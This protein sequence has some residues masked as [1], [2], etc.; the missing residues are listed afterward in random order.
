[1]LT[2][3]REVLIE[4]LKCRFENHYQ[5][6]NG[7]GV[8]DD[9]TNKTNCWGR[10]P[11]DCSFN[12]SSCPFEEIKDKIL[13]PVGF[14]V[15]STTEK[16]IK[17]NNVFR[18][19]NIVKWKNW[20]ENYSNTSSY[21]QLCKRGSNLKWIEI[22]ANF[23][24]N[25]YSLNKNTIISSYTVLPFVD[26]YENTF[27]VGDIVE[28]NKNA[29]IFKSI[30]R[31]EG[32]TKR[33]EITLYQFIKKYMEGDVN[34]EPS[35]PF[36][37]IP[38]YINHKYD[39]LGVLEPCAKEW[40]PK[41][42]YYKGDVVLYNG[43]DYIL[44]DGETCEL[45]NVTCKLHKLLNKY[46]PHENEHYV[47]LPKSEFSLSINDGVYNKVYSNG[48]RIIYYEE[49]DNNTVFYYP[50]ITHKAKFIEESGSFKFDTEKWW[51]NSIIDITDENFE[52]KTY[53]TTSESRLT[54]VRRYKKSIDEDGNALPF[55]ISDDDSIDTE[56][57]FKLGISNVNLNNSNI[58]RGDF[59]TEIYLENDINSVSLHFSYEDSENEVKIQKIMSFPE[60]IDIPE[61]IKLSS[62]SDII[63]TKEKEE[64]RVVTFVGTCNVNT[65]IRPSYMEAADRTTY[66]TIGTITFV[67][68][69]DVILDESYKNGSKIVEIDYYSGIEYNESYPYEIVEL[70]VNYI[71]INET[72][73]NSDAYSLYEYSLKEGDVVSGE[74]SNNID[75]NVNT[76][77]LI[78]SDVD[79]YGN[80]IY[81]RV[82]RRYNAFDISYDNPLTNNNIENDNKNVILSNITFNVGA[83]DEF[84]FNNIDTY[85]NDELI[86][87]EDMTKKININIE[88][89]KSSAFERLHILTEI[90][91]LND[92]EKYKNN[93]FKI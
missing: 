79:E 35:I 30:F 83:S 7:D 41:E 65:P 5:F 29:D 22:E 8:I 85:K 76:L 19:K 84:M 34:C 9:N 37:D 36:F 54:S 40:D 62:T 60:T 73:N 42:K 32:I 25:D 28:V 91:T 92:L 3:K 17:L 81:Y 14:H 2:V 47:F 59:I 24:D 44:T 20:L 61:T 4:D 52:V 68:Y 69:R 78:Y 64:E 89:G 38:L 88:R 33:N 87:V 46:F 86:G 31:G 21:F 26:N 53:T 74:K 77:G 82:L 57:I 58:I 80:N 75:Y 16:T 70:G 51:K 50:S 72:R 13:S 1:M 11:L 15:N 12:D 63:L 10:I 66:S 48:R 18:Y 67:Y 23:F 71:P 45:T 49:K 27:N 6:I 56:L 55:I 93:Y 39:N 90:K 43:E